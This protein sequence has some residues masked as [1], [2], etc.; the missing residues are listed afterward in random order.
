MLLQ[1]NGNQWVL[2]QVTNMSGI[3]VQ[4]RVS[5]SDPNILFLLFYND[6]LSG[7][8]YYRIFKYQNNNFTEFHNNEL[9]IHDNP[10]LTTLD[11]EVAFGWDRKVYT[12]LN[13]TPK[14]FYDFSSTIKL[15][16]AFWGRNSKDL[17][18]EAN[19]GVGH[20]NGEDIQILYP[21]D[22]KFYIMNCLFFEKEVFILYYEF[23]NFKFYVLRGKLN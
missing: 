23:G 9:N 13:G 17:F 19:G 2:K 11:G 5:K 3:F 18:F 22:K 15:Y 21:I 8:D 12:L 1:F 7:N 10:W 4:I 16:S 6:N 14:L 20:F